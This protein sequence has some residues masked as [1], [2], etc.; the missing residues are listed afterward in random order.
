[1]T[2][3]L[4]LIGALAL[5]SVPIVIGWRRTVNEANMARAMGIA[6]PKRRFDPERIARQTGT[7]L[8]FNQL[9]FGFL[10][11]VGGGLVIG[12]PM[13]VLSALMLAAAGGLIYAGSLSNLRQEFRLRQAKDILRSL[14]VIQTL[15]EQG[16][17]LTDSLEEAARAAGPDGQAVLNDLVVRLRAASADRFAAVVREWTTD[18]D[19]PGVD[20]LGTALIAALEGRIEIGPLMASLRRTLNGV[21]EVLSRARAAAKGVEWQARFL[22]I[23]PPLVLLFMSVT[24]PRI[25]Q[26]FRSNPILVLPVLIGS[27]VS[28]LLSNRMIR[29]GLSIEASIGLQAGGQGEIRLDRM[30]RVL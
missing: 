13:G 6:P 11:W 1:M 9:L 20:M 15:L 12:L 26:A 23:Y 8:K 28:Y 25:G 21:V 27:G 4:A 5:A 17:T 30:G 2:T 10:V 14:G 19:N 7:G 18:W 29:N 16:R 22:A 24:T 3:L